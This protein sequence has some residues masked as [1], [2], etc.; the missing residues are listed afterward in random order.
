MK[1][2]KVVNKKRFAIALICFSLIL[3][4]AVGGSLAYL[5]TSG[6]SVKNIFTPAFVS[7]EVKEVFNGTTKSNIQI[8]NTG[9]TSAYIRVA[10]VQN[11][12]DGDGIVVPGTLPAL[13]AALGDNWELNTRDGFYYYKDA[14]D[15]NGE[16]TALF[17]SAI[18]EPTNG[19]S[20][21]HL[22][23][24]V[25]ADGIQSQGKGKG[26]KECWGVDLNTDQ[27]GNE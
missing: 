8:K 1:Q 19:P 4:F 24:S 26:Y 7:T 10:V 3:V 2:Y 18:I 12:V 9:N 6:G 5:Y 13:P 11:W 15:P 21:A 25:L 27:G 20:G 23:V 16:T 17:S 14:V 22:Q